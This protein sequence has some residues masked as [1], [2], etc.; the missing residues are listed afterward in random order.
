MFVLY[1][2]KSLMYLGYDSLSLVVNYQVYIST[3]HQEH[4]E[5]TSSIYL[6][7]YGDRGDS[8]LRLLAKSDQPIKFQRGMVSM[9][10]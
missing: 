6:C 3:G 4:A 5:T 9:L 10:K 8:G 1:T 7:I 2:F